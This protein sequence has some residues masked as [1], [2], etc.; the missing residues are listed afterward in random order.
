MFELDERNEIAFSHNPFSMPQGGLDALMGM[1]PLEI[2]AYQYD[3]VCNGIELSSGAVRNHDINIMIKAFEI[4]GYSKQH[5]EEKFG[6]L[7][8]AFQFGAPPH[9]G[10]APG[11]DRV[12]MLLSD[13]DTIRDVIA[14]PLNSKA[15]DLLMGTPGN[16]THQQLRD[17]HIQVN[18][19]K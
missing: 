7:F 10:I 13:S 6:A 2:L 5:V 12:L 14:F 3:I 8:N 4:A 11:I 17:V 9:A 18:V 1:E 15:E 19:K 16:V